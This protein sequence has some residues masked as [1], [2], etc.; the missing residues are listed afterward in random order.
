MVSYFVSLFAFFGSVADGVV[1]PLA[2]VD[3]GVQ[4]AAYQLT[5][6]RRGMVDVEFALQMVALVL[7][8]SSQKSGDFLFVGLEIFINPFETYV[9]DT[10]NRFAEVGQRQ[11]AFVALHDFIAENFNFRINQSQFAV[12][13]FGKSLADGIGV[14]N[15]NAVVES[16]LRRSQSDTFA[17]LHCFKHVADKFLQVGVVGGNFLRN[18]TEH[19]VSVQ[20]DR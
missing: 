13:A 6:D 8:Y 15:D 17:V 4:F 18:G 2:S 16:D 11:T 3:Y 10:R 12:F 7:H 20:I 14:D 19:P 9:F 1:N 5:A